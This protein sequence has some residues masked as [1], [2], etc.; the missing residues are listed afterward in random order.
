M[1]GSPTLPTHREGLDTHGNTSKKAGPKRGP[2]TPTLPKNREES[3][4]QGKTLEKTGRKPRPFPHTGKSRAPGAKPWKWLG[5]P[6]FF[7]ATK[8]ET[9]LWHARP[10]FYY[11]QLLPAVGVV[12][13]STSAQSV[14]E[15]AGRGSRCLWIC[16]GGIRG[17]AGTH[18]FADWRAG[19]RDA[20]DR[21]AS[22]EAKGVAGDAHETAEARCGAIRISVRA[23]GFAVAVL[24]KEVLR[25]Q[26]M[27]SQK[28][29]GEA[30]IHA[31]ESGE[32]WF[33]RVAGGLDME[34]LLLV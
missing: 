23:G 3:G 32:A 6:P 27:E 9:L 4:T 30:G 20:F 18:S 15:D 12:G 14:R 13:N 1:A 28:E 11:L 10:A 19:E 7:Y 33:G 24:A 21:A 26:C 2:K 31:H 22:F 5:R 29:D 17:D 34:F 25:F 8:A 16:A